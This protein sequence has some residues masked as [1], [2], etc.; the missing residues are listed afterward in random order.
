MICKLH[1]SDVS[2]TTPRYTCSGINHSPAHHRMQ[3]LP[4]ENAMQRYNFFYKQQNISDIFCNFAPDFIDLYD[5]GALLCTL[6]VCFRAIFA[7]VSAHSMPMA[8]DA[9]LASYIKNM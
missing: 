9:P 2:E 7:I 3:H 5:V 4:S 8:D 1:P 6:A